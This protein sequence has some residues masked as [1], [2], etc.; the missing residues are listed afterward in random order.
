M[1]GFK[2]IITLIQQYISIYLNVY[3]LISTSF[4]LF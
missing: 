4:K 1:G 3:P 2:N